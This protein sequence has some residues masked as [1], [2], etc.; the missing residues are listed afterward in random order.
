MFPLPALAEPPLFEPALALLLEPPLPLVAP[1]ALVP[2]VA[3][4]PAALVPALPF[5]ALPLEPGEVLE[6][7]AEQASARP[8]V[9]RL[10]TAKG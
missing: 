10:L 5:V 9:K 1:P 3:V 7:A 6:L 2:A 4:A 8:R